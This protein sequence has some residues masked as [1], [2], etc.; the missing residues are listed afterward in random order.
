MYTNDDDIC[1]P[2]ALSDLQ[3]VGGETFTMNLDNSQHFERFKVQFTR[4]DGHAKDKAPVSVFEHD[5]KLLTA[6]QESGKFFRY[7]FNNL[8]PGNEY[9]AKVTPVDANDNVIPNALTQET[10]AVTTCCCDC[11]SI[12]ADDTSGRP[13]NL[14]ATQVAGRSK[15]P[16]SFPI[17][18]ADQK[19]SHPHFIIFIPQSRLCLSTIQSVQ[20][21]MPSLVQKSW[22]SSWTILTSHSKLVST[23]NL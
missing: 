2:T 5:G 17:S 13:I 9:T 1:I 4:P 15:F 3:A 10:V 21:L 14:T 6:P 11:N 20:R 12:T 16:L 7:T 8:L 18:L 19:K 23:S 22:K